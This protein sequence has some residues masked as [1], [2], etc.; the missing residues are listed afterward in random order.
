MILGS[1][2]IL[3]DLEKLFLLSDSLENDKGAWVVA[4]PMAFG[5]GILIQNSTHRGRY[6][7]R[8]K[9]KKIRKNKKTK[10]K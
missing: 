6:T 9:K 4:T 3:L 1:E 2:P 7:I 10:K 8:K 5:T